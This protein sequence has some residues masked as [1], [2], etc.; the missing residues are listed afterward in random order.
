MI[1]TCPKC[2]T[3]FLIEEGQIGEG[4][5]TVRCSACGEQ[6]RATPNGSAPAPLDRVAE[7]PETQAPGTLSAVFESEAEGPV[8]EAIP[9]DVHATDAELGPIVAP[10]TMQSRGGA[11]RE[12][13]L[14]LALIV[15]AVIAVM[16]AVYAF[17][18]EIMR[19][20]PAMRGAYSAIGLAPASPSPQPIAPATET[21]AQGA[22]AQ[23]APVQ[24]DG[25]RPNG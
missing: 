23:G 14:N 18:A 6:W 2:A 16:V 19:V 4:G 21:P 12:P 24:S 3:R 9:A 7:D 25:N 13:G 15:V 17:R 10:I 1:L 22:P 8:P 20:A 11:V 5:R